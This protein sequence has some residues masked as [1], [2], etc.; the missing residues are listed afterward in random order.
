MTFLN[1]KGQTNACLLKYMDRAQ[2]LSLHLKFNKKAI[3]MRAELNKQAYNDLQLPA[4]ARDYL[5]SQNINHS[6]EIS[7]SAQE[8]EAASIPTHLF[9]FLYLHCK[10]HSL[11]LPPQMETLRFI[12]PRIEMCSTY[13]IR[14]YSIHRLSNTDGWFH[15]NFLVLTKHLRRPVK[16]VAL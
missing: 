7:T 4:Y 8:N 1:I 3:E 6:K 2:K 10:L 12:Y 15:E 9:S 13:L 11:K 14:V 5:I 16:D